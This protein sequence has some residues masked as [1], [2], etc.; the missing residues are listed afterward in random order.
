MA[1]E[2]LVVVV[3]FVVVDEVVVLVVYVVVVV[4]VV[5][6]MLAFMV[7]FGV[8][9]VMDVFAFILPSESSAKPSIKELIKKQTPSTNFAEVCIALYCFGP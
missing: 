7:T 1:V 4:A 5:V 8:L 3:A 2:V 9:V 6:F